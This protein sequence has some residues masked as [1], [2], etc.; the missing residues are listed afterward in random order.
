MCRA[1]I[2]SIEDPFVSAS[3]SRCFSDRIVSPGRGEDGCQP[4]GLVGRQVVCGLLEVV[5]GCGF[6]SIDTLS[7]FGDVE[8]QFENTF[9]R[10]LLFE[11]ASDQGFPGL[12]KQGSFGREIEIFGQLLGNGAPAAFEFT[13]LEVVFGGLFDPFPVESFVGE[14]RR[15][16][17]PDH[18]LTER[19]SGT[20]TQWRLALWP[21]VSAWAC[22]V[23]MSAV[24]GGLAVRKI[25]TSGMVSSQRNRT[26]PIGRQSPRIRKTFTRERD[27]LVDFLI[28]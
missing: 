22:R 3:Q 5:A 8:V 11:G 24:T 28:V 23:S 26:A 18:R 7:P 14:E 20:H 10:E 15:I 12:S 17:R 1:V 2:N 16:F 21:C 9:L 27:C 25:E 19:G 4:G 6:R 13:R